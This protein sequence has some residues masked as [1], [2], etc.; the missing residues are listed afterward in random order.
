MEKRK[1]KKKKKKRVSKKFYCTLC[2][3]IVIKP[4]QIKKRKNYSHGKKSKST[5]NYTHICDGGCLIELR[6]KDE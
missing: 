5:I 1:R 4:S 3:K 6:K 2:E